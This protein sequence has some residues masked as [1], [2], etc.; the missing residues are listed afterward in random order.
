MFEL[1]NIVKI[2]EIFEVKAGDAR[3]HTKLQEMHD[4]DGLVVLQP[5]LKNVPLRADD[6]VFEFAFFRPNGVYVFDARF[7]SAYE[8]KGVKLC[9]FRQISE[10][11]KVQR[12]QCY[13]LPIV[14]NVEMYDDEENRQIKYKGKTTTLS[15]KSVQFTCFTRFPEDK[16]LTVKIFFS[17]TETITLKGKVLRCTEPLVKNDPY[18]IVILFLDSYS[19]N[20]T[21]LSKYIF[22]QQIIARNNSQRSIRENGGTQH[23]SEGN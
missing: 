3:V 2:G 22:K 5:T 11:K 19:K 12:R 17:K 16:K 1:G 14:L 18:D 20:I 8:K 13:R 9:R 6:D 23:D 15:E 7:E 21:R 4:E 10:I